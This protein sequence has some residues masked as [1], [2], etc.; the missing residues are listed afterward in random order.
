[1]LGRDRIL[2]AQVEQQGEPVNTTLGSM[3]NERQQI[4]HACNHI[5]QSASILDQAHLEHGVKD[6]VFLLVDFYH[7]VWSIC[8][9]VHQP[10]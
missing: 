5:I 1:M 7:L 4:R 3:E 6:R 8:R 2:Q 10:L 9:A